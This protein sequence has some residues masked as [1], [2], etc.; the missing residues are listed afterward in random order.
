[1][2]HR[3]QNVRI[4]TVVCA[5]IG[6]WGMWYPELTT[7]ADTYAIVQEDGTVLPASEVVKCDFGELY[8]EELLQADNSQIRFRSKFLQWL[9]EY[10]EKVGSEDDFR[11]NE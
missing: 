10:F 11:E 7:A 3:W 1:M 2:N 9:E 6:W 5:A 8:C 4:A